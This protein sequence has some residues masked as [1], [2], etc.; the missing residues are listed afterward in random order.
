LTLGAGELFELQSAKHQMGG[1]LLRFARSSNVRNCEEW[2]KFGLKTKGP[3]NMYKGFILDK[4]FG[5]LLVPHYEGQKKKT[6]H[7]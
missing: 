2:Q 3:C 4:L 5:P 6:C 1:E 7:I